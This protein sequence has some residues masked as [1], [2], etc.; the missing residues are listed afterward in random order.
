MFIPGWLSA[1]MASGLS[2]ASIRTSWP[3]TKLPEQLRHKER[4]AAQTAPRS[5]GGEGG[6]R[7]GG[8][9]GAGARAATQPAAGGGGLGP[10]RQQKGGRR[11]AN[12]PESHH[13][14]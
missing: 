2:A 5:G 7:R 9:A 11:R 14:Y 4:G 10:E 1:R 12:R 3:P 6:R 13:R 8:G